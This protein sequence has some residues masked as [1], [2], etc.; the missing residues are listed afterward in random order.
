MAYWGGKAVTDRRATAIYSAV[1]AT[2]E[3]VR[4]RKDLPTGK[5][6]SSTAWETFSKPMKAQGEMTAMLTTWEMARV[7][8]TKAGA[9]ERSCRKRAAAHT[10][11]MPRKNTATMTTMA[12]IMALLQ[13]M[14]STAASSAA[15][16]VSSTSPRYTS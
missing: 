5:V 6:N 8:G 11:R 12:R 7:S 14:H 3:T 13:R 10:P 1:V 16:T 4:I 9:R 15:A 2:T